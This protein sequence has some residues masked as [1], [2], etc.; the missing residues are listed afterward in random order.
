M[1]YMRMNFRRDQLHWS[2]WCLFTNSYDINGGTGDYYLNKFLHP[3]DDD[4]PEA[5]R[6][7]VD[8]DGLRGPIVFRRDE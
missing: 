1:K 8:D 7:P 5:Y 6:D 2:S 4:V 3:D